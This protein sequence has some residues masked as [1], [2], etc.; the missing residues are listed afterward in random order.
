MIIR[1]IVQASPAVIARSYTCQTWR[2]FSKSVLNRTTPSKAMGTSTTTSI[3]HEERTAA[4][5]REHGMHKVILDR[6]EEVNTNIRLL[7]LKMHN[8]DEQLQ[9]CNLGNRMELC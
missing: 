7:K 8:G 5:P 2:A 9:A 4:E 3:P 6:I 1:K